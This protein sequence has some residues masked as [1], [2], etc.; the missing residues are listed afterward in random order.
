[1]RAHRD[2]LHRPSRSARPSH[3]ALC[4]GPSASAGS[5]AGSNQIRVIRPSV[6]VVVSD[7]WASRLRALV[8]SSAVGRG[9]CRGGRGR[10]CR[11]RRQG[12][13][14]RRMRGGG[15][16]MRPT[17]AVMVLL[18]VVGRAWPP[19][20]GSRSSRVLSSLARAAR[21]GD[22]R[23][24]G[25]FTDTQFGAQQVPD[26]PLPLSTLSV[27]TGNPKWGVLLPDGLVVVYQPILD[28]VTP[29][30]RDRST[31]RALARAPRRAIY[32]VGIARWCESSG[33]GRGWEGCQRLGGYLAAELLAGVVV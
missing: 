21:A 32:A 24:R 18:T 1:M 26:R 3:S 2:E 5:R 33:V 29:G 8:R 31:S 11:R 23:R 20:P 6:V 13:C 10:A 16:G 12:R 15:E 14:R 25:A 19:S 17:W 22:H 27:G 7:L 9:R 28:P 4:K 30:G